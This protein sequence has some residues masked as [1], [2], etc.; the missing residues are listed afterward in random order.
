[1]SGPKSTEVAPLTHRTLEHLLHTARDLKV[2]SLRS[3]NN[4]VR[5]VVHLHRDCTTAPSCTPARRARH[6]HSIS[7]RHSL[8]A[9][10]NKRSMPPCRDGITRRQFDAR[11]SRG[12][13]GAEIRQRHSA[14]VRCAR[15]PCL[16]H[17]FHHRPGR[18]RR[19]PHSHRRHHRHHRHL[20]R[21]V[22]I[23][24]SETPRPKT[25]APH[26]RSGDRSGK[27]YTRPSTGAAAP[28]PQSGVRRGRWS[29]ASRRSH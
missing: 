29:E 9:T 25:R 8:S 10:F 20:H 24:P 7:R 19:R 4:A 12:Y 2:G 15:R 26:A 17:L 14:P 23:S 6:F 11:E 3:G 28:P 5:P 21:L 18:L 27:D 22:A 13:L 16:H 1:M